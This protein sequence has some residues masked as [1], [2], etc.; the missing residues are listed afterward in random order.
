M[1]RV[2]QSVNSRSTKYPQEKQKIYRENCDGSSF[3]EH[4]K[5]KQRCQKCKQ[6]YNHP[7][8]LIPDPSREFETVF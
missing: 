1:K 3:C 5:Q 4:G 6:S 2:N 7:V 8:P